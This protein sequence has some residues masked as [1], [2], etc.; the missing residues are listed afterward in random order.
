MAFV[1]LV[2][3]VVPDYDE[4]I[5]YYT[6][7]CGFV[8]HTDQHLDAY[9]RWVVIGPADRQGCQLLLAKASTTTQVAHIGNQTGGRVAFF[10]QSHNFVAD[11]TRMQQLGVEFAESPRH[12]AYGMVVKWRDRYGNMWDLLGA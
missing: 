10:L 11:Y 1:A 12:E 5:A 7:V 2:T 3:V 8:V 9:K 4:A 6:A